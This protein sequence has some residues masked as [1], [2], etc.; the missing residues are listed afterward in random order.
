VLSDKQKRA[1]YDRYGAE[2]LQRGTGGMPGQ[3][4]G[5]T[6][7]HGFGGAQGSPDFDFFAEMFRS[8][9]GFGGGFASN[10]G[11]SP[12]IKRYLQVTLEEL[13]NGCNKKLEVCSHFVINV[14][15][16]I[17]QLRTRTG[18][19]ETI[20][21]MNVEIKPG[22]HDGIKL[23]YANRGDELY[24]EQFIL[25]YFLVL[26]LR[27]VERRYCVCAIRITACHLQAREV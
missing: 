12:T 16:L 8:G 4:F 26:T 27:I 19:G 24:G 1:I 17:L 14:A 22:Y 11:K 23:T 21:S 25:S 10:G 20:Q 9:G 7:F 15:F 6:H 3:G 2:G 5:A 18:H 13:Y